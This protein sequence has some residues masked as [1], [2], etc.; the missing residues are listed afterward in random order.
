MR[1]FIRKTTLPETRIRKYELT[2]DKASRII[3]T[4]ERVLK[5]EETERAACQNEN[6]RPRWFRYFLDLDIDNKKDENST[7]RITKDDWMCWEEKFLTDLTK[8]DATI[9]PDNFHKIY[10]EVTSSQLSEREQEILAYRYQDNMTFEEIGHIYSVSREC[11]QQLVEK[12]LRTLR[13]PKYRYYLC[14]G[15]EYKEVL[16]K[17]HTAQAE[18]DSICVKNY[19]KYQEK[20]NEKINE[21]KSVLNN[22]STE[23]RNQKED[24]NSLKD[25][26]L[27]KMGLSTRAY[28]ALKRYILS[29]KSYT[30]KCATAD[31]VAELSGRL[32]DIRGLGK[33]SI[34]E[35]AQK[36]LE[37]GVHIEEVKL[38]SKEAYYD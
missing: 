4:I 23:V 33:L 31:D 27:E 15:Q 36:M 18:Y 5:N 25:I 3:N 13:N 14:Y 12:S 17:L 21:I 16:R 7:V 32:K 9:V 38:L 28:H 22:T 20:K 26:S 29:E 11:I 24:K 30:S 1:E 34:L 2:K 37:Y 19:E 10:L 6:I 35:I 8:D